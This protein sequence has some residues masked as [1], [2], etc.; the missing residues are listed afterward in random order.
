MSKF[1]DPA[2]DIER[3]VNAESIGELVPDY[4]PEEPI[5]RLNLTPSS[6][7][8]A[9]SIMTGIIAGVISPNRKAFA[10]E[11]VQPPPSVVVIGDSLIAGREDAL[12]QQL[13]MS[14]VQPLQIDG[15]GSRQTIF[16]ACESN[17]LSSDCQRFLDGLRT[18]ER[19]P[20]EIGSASGVVLALGT[21]DSVA[22]FKDE[23]LRI[24]RRTHEIGTAPDQRAPL[25]IIPEIF[26]ESSRVSSAEKNAIIF[27][28]VIQ[29]QEEG[30]NATSLPYKSFVDA[31]LR[32][33]GGVASDEVHLTPAGYQ[34]LAEFETELIAETVSNYHSTILY[35]S[36][37]VVPPATSV[38]VPPASP[39]SEIITP[40]IDLDKPFVLDISVPKKSEIINLGTTDNTVQVDASTFVLD[41]T[42]PIKTTEQTIFPPFN[43]EVVDSEN[44]AASSQS[45]VFDTSLP[46]KNQLAGELTP[47]QVQVTLDEILNLSEE[48]EVE[49]VAPII[50]ALIVETAPVTPS[51]PEILA[52]PEIF[53]IGEYYYIDENNVV[54]DELL[55]EF[56]RTRPD[57]FAKA[58]PS[59]EFP[60]GD[61]YR[62]PDNFPGLPYY[63]NDIAS[64]N[65]RFAS[66]EVVA[67]VFILA[68]R[69]IDR[70]ARF[71]GLEDK[72]LQ[73]AV[74]MHK[75]HKH[76]GDIDWGLN[77]IPEARLDEFLDMIRLRRFDGS[78]YIRHIVTGDETLEYTGDRY[79]DSLGYER[80]NLI[81]QEEH[82]VEPGNGAHLHLSFDGGQS[83]PFFQPEAN[84]PLTWGLNHPQ[85][86]ILGGG[87][88]PG[89]TLSQTNSDGTNLEI[90]SVSN[91]NSIPV[92]SGFIININNKPRTEVV[93]FEPETVTIE[94]IDEILLEEPIEVKPLN[95]NRGNNNQQ[96]GTKES[97]D[98]ILEIET[99]VVDSTDWVEE[100]VVE[101]ENSNQNR[102]NNQAQEILVPPV[103]ASAT[104]PVAA[105]IPEPTPLPT[106][107]PEAVPVPQVETVPLRD[108]FTN[109]V[110]QYILP[111]ASPENI[112]KYTP[113][114]L[115]ALHEFGIAD[116]QIACYAFATIQP[117][118]S[119]FAPIREYASGMD[120]DITVDADKAEDLGNDQ[121]GDGPKY[122]GGGFVQITGKGNHRTYGDMIGV[123]LV[124]NP[125]LSTDPVI[126]ARTMAA[127]LS[128]RVD[129]I[130]NTLNSGDLAGARRLVNGGTHGLDRFSEAW[131][132]CTESVVL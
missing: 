18:V 132:R 22:D 84:V 81:L 129:K 91:T 100:E 120:Y 47:E 109:E 30:I 40:T 8:I 46:I 122:R 33:N 76:G 31:S 110:V 123:D 66:V 130:R 19:Y 13:T 126:A 112:E 11:I 17:V 106:P 99:E 36:S 15:L 50:E 37:V 45:M 97:V 55:I 7:I 65:E 108:V 95:Q 69:H 73:D 53:D 74:S 68:H 54:H 44:G 89:T 61:Y 60:E 82:L 42:K 128:V 24:S 16:G 43:A 62:I 79:L 107:S 121:P 34:Q 116:P 12:G 51:T 90:N 57:I 71:P 72:Y 28:V 94:T 2:K 104:E 26:G 25:I 80:P 21:N 35:P 111:N 87:Y 113:L 101:I 114:I 6:A 85:A 52:T 5:Q 1:Y 102:G 10:Q 9:G 20:T 23:L 63:F 3:L 70:Q 124:A 38:V 115:S 27:E 56:I 29:L 64:P 67:G 93:E 117:E 77:N 125:E 39:I 131:K 105:P 48:V 41:I 103:S 119:G 88:V 92:S 49:A 14:T 75:E 4:I 118:T 58:L 32:P 86:P 59:H 98:T 96:T 127:F 78:A 83:G